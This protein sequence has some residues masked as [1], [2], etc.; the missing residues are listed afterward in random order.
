MIEYIKNKKLIKHFLLL[1]SILFT[2]LGIFSQSSIE[3]LGGVNVL[4]RTPKTVARPHTITSGVNLGILYEYS[5]TDYFALSSGLNTTTRGYAGRHLYF[6]PSFPN[7]PI[8]H[9]YILRRKVQY[10][11]IPIYAN[12][13]LNLSPRIRLLG[14]VGPFVGVSIFGMY[15]EVYTDPNS[16]GSPPETKL[17]YVKS[18]DL[19]DPRWEAGIN[20]RL[21]IEL[22]RFSI[23]A[24]YSMGLV[25]H[26]Q[27]Y[28]GYP[29]VFYPEEKSRQWAIQFSLGYR[30]S[31]EKK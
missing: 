29:I 19:P 26:I 13:Y 30:F 11:D 10:L 16:S 9:E 25:N 6:P 31:F 2:A 18:R 20:Y 5:F 4:S 23:S 17:K 27:N 24:N 14:A 1:L 8:S 21:G 3:I 28:F 22:W 7:P 15:D 12:F